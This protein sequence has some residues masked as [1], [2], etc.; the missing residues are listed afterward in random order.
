MASRLATKASFRSLAAV[1][2]Q[3]SLESRVKKCSI[4]STNLLWRDETWNWNRFGTGLVK[5]STLEKGEVYS[6]PTFTMSFCSSFECLDGMISSF[7]SRNNE[8][9][10]FPKSEKISLHTRDLECLKFR[11]WGTRNLRLYPTEGTDRVQR[12][13]QHL[14][15]HNTRRYMEPEHIFRNVQSLKVLAEGRRTNHGRGIVCIVTRI[16]NH[17]RFRGRALNHF[18]T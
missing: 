8:K 16:R 10:V 11:R 2:W 6:H 9:F 7:L 3:S 1:E 4:F 5:A 12:N 17:K 15:G 13:P 18:L 14:N